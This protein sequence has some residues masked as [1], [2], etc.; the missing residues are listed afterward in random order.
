MYNFVFQFHSENQQKFGF[1]TFELGSDYSWRSWRFVNGSQGEE[2]L[3]S[4]GHWVD[5]GKGEISAFSADNKLYA[6]VALSENSNLMVVSLVAKN[7]LALGV[8]Q[9]TLMQGD[10]N[11]DYTLLGTKGKIKKAYLAE[12]V[13]FKMN[14][15]PNTNKRG[16]EKLILTYNKPWSGFF[17]DKGGEILG[18]CSKKGDCFCLNLGTI[19]REQYVVVAIK[20]K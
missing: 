16:N 5:G 1:G 9:Q 18:I 12:K 11:G 17:T 6:T 8:K 7:G 2:K 10:I 20:K 15:D 4:S 14:K 3:Y 13:I 19:T